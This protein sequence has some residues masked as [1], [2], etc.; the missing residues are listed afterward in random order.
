[1]K[2]SSLLINSAMN[3]IVIDVYDPILKVQVT[4]TESNAFTDSHTASDKHGDQ[5]N[6]IS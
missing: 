1:M 5:S 6:P 4:P 3:Q 2:G